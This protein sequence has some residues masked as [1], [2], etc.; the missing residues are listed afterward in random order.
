MLAFSNLDL[1]TGLRHFLLGRFARRLIG[2]SGI[3]GVPKLCDPTFEADGTVARDDFSRLTPFARACMDERGGVSMQNWCLGELGTAPYPE[4]RLA[5]AIGRDL[6]RR[7][8]HGPVIVQIRDR[9]HRCNGKRLKRF[10][11]CEMGGGSV[12]PVH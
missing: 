2:S 5:L 9:A 1:L 7:M 10:Y 12:I 11:R 4:Q 6:A 8:E 3:L